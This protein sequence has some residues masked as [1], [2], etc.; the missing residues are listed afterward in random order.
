MA[1]RPQHTGDSIRSERSFQSSHGHQTPVLSRKS[2][3][4]NTK[5]N[6]AQIGVPLPKEAGDSDGFGARPRMHKRSLTGEYPAREYEC[7]HERLGC[8][9]LGDVRILS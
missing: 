5:I 9:W 3:I 4:A 8:L 1:L 6:T 7:R 2:S